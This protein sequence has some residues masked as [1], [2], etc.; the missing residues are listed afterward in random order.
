M[1]TWRLSD[2]TLLMG[3]FVGANGLTLTNG[4]GQ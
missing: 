4:D 1:D 3:M 2:V